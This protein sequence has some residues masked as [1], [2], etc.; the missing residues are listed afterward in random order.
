[1]AD[2][3]RIS[4]ERLVRFCRSVFVS[5]GLAEG[6]ARV[7][8]DVLIAADTRGIPSHGVARLWRYV[9]GLQT[10]LMLPKVE[11]QILV[12]SDMSLVIDARG[13]MGAPIS[14][15]TM[16]AVID[17]AA[18]TGSAFASVR[19]SNHFGIAGY[20]A[21]KALDRDMLGIA[22]TN[23]AAL[24]VPTFGREAM[25]GTNP[26]AFAAPA[27][28]EKAFVLD[29]STTV[30]TRGKIEVYERKEKPLPL[31]WA[32]G[33]TGEP[34]TDATVILKDMQER[35]GGGILPLGGDG[36]A[37]G[38]H[39]GYG[40]AVLVDILCAVLGGA[41]FGRDVRD[42]ATSSARVSHFFGAVRIDRFRDPQDF[43]RDMDDMLERLRTSP[44]GGGHRARLLCRPERGGAGERCAGQ[45]R[46][47]VGT[48]AP[49]P[50]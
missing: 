34:A 22:M 39:K 35:L 40:M 4:C 6:D 45:R 38:G 33:K 20:Y 14:A 16:E 12:E 25:V 18:S 21:M 19:D 42:T 1:M 13:G 28:R 47:A 41:P 9:N 10:G 11:P 31:G 5:L 46:G 27:D 36:E 29:M 48:D 30:V 37:F 2:E 50:L 49:G 32:V 23:T 17:K 43:R 44:P 3:V 26:I 8:G 15:R 7:A 24:S